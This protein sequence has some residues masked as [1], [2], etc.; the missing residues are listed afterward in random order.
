MERLRQELI[1]KID[2]AINEQKNIIYEYEVDKITFEV[3]AEYRENTSNTIHDI[4][5]N[6][7][8]NDKEND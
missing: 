6:L 3:I 2:K 4:L 7:M 8:K 5:L 1:A